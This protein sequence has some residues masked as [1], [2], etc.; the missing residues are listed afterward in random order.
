MANNNVRGI[1]KRIPKG[2][3]DKWVK[4]YATKYPKAEAKGYL[5]GSD[6]LFDLLDDSARCAGIWFYKGINDDGKECLVLYKADDQGN[7]L[8]SNMN[9]IGAASNGSLDDPADDG[10]VCPPTCPTNGP[11]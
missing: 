6:I 9:S 8:V 4:S 11:R 2:Q 1:G 7:I 3:A 5:Y 10:D